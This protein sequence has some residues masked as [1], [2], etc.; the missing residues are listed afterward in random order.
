MTSRRRLALFVETATLVLVAHVCLPPIFG[1]P[2]PWWWV[3]R[4]VV[5]TNSTPDDY[6][7]A[8]QGQ[9]KNM[10]YNAWMEI[11]KDLPGGAD[12]NVVAL[13]NSFFTTNDDYLPV[14]IGQLKNVAQPFYNQLIN[15]GLTNAYPWSEG[16]TTD[17]CA[18]ANIGQLKNL[19][20]WEITNMLP[21]ATCREVVTNA[22]IHG[23]HVRVL[24]AAAY[25][26]LT[27]G[28]GTVFN[29]NLEPKGVFFIG[30]NSATL[31]LTDFREVSSTCTATIIVEGHRPGGEHWQRDPR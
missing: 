30:T 8:N 6:A 11:E 14:N 1:S 9:V 20:A 17:D 7:L 21:R 23:D 12:S 25:G 28:I 5:N 10:A 3:S 31:I 29:L 26:G 24:A 15:L 19:F 22:P 16:A 4:G 2:G 13:M 27:N 18:I